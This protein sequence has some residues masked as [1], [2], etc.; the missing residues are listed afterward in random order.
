M[1]PFLRA[2]EEERCARRLSPHRRPPVE[3]ES[4]FLLAGVARF[5]HRQIEQD[6]GSRP[7]P[8]PAATRPTGAPM[9]RGAPDLTAADFDESLF[10]E[11]KRCF[12]TWSARR[13]T[14][15][16][17][18]SFICP[19]LLLEVSLVDEIFLFLRCLAEISEF[20]KEVVV[21]ATIYLERLL[22][23]HPLLH[24]S[25]CNWRPLLVASLHLASK[26]W[27]DVHAWNAEFT[28]FLREVVGVRYPARLLHLLELKFLVGLEYRMEVSAELFAAYY[29]SLVELEHQSSEFHHGEMEKRDGSFPSPDHGKYPRAQSCF[30]LSALASIGTEETT[31]SRPNAT[32][33]TSPHSSQFVSLSSPSSVSSGVSP[34]WRVAS[35][36]SN[37][38][39]RASLSHR[40]SYTFSPSPSHR[41]P[42]NVKAERLDPRNPFIGFLRHAAVA[43]PPSPYI[44]RRH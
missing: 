7:P 14:R 15:K 13:R 38:S 42:S 12:G 21:I 39:V 10:L 43:S 41:R 37:L 19:C 27:E 40:L 18:W 8:P 22:G 34:I 3:S 24:L 26:T 29:F 20:K 9:G 6:E 23:K 33:A 28:Q 44:Q 17:W 1:T 36:A 25:T 31:I 5:L 11:P 4:D 30:D 16:S 32:N 35:Q 2:G